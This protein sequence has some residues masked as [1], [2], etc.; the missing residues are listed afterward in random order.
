M[1]EIEA[2]IAETRAALET[3][4]RL[5]Q[6]PENRHALRHHA[7]PTGLYNGMVHPIV[8]YALRGAIWYPRRVEPSGWNALP[9]KDESAHQWVA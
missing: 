6:I 3:D 1:K 9:R 5:T 7:R 8:P 4:A 2:W